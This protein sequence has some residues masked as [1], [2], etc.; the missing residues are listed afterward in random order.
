MSEIYDLTSRQGMK[1]ALALISSVTGP[2]VVL[3]TFSMLLNLFTPT[4]AVSKQ[5]EAAV[6]IIKAGKESGVD[7]MTLVMEE[8]EGA[9]FSAPIEGV[10]ISAGIGRKG[11]ITIEVT[12]K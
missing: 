11:K 7:K 8:Q 12:Y 6:G 10:N 2:N 9:H 4:N 1:D 3:G 5:A